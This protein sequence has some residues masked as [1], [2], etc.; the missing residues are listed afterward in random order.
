MCT[1][2][3]ICVH[4][5]HVFSRKLVHKGPKLVVVLCNGNRVQLTV[6]DLCWIHLYRLMNEKHGNLYE[7]IMFYVT[8]VP[9]KRGISVPVF[10]RIEFLTAVLLNTPNF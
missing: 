8:A 6:S 7:Y 2:Q 1:C 10:T 9:R 3:V 4:L 5:L